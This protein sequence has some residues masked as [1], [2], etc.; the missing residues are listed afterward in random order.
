MLLRENEEAPAVIP[1][2]SALFLSDSSPLCLEQRVFLGPA[3]EAAPSLMFAAC[4]R[5]P[6]PRLAAQHH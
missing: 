1:Q 3:E 2:V 6:L 4:S 5:F